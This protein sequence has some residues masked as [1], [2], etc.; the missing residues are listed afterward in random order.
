LSALTI[1]WCTYTDPEIAHVGMF[2]KEAREKN[3]PVKTITVLMHEVDRAIADG[4]EDGF[5]K[6]HIGEV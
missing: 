5:V 6:I 3:I 4:E 2:V 1:P